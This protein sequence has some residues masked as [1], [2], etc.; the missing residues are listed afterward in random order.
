MRDGAYTTTYISEEI[1]GSIEL[2]DYGSDVSVTG[3]TLYRLPFHKQHP[4]HQPNVPAIDVTTIGHA[5]NKN[6]VKTIML[7]DLLYVRYTT[8]RI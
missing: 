2:Y 8:V 7:L 6:M 5:V 4:I 1:P 3:K